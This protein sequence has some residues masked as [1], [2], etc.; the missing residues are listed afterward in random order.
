MVKNSKEII[1]T[2]L[3][4]WRNISIEEAKALRFGDLDRFEK[5]NSE[6]THIQSQLD[7]IL[8]DIDTSGFSRKVSELMEKI[9]KLNSS[10]LKELHKGTKELS[11][12]IALLRKNKVSMKG[13]KQNKSIA[14]R[15]MNKHT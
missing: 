1:L 9:R 13:Y 8:A 12:R 14:P 11:E 2:L 6:S 4:A 3:N 5:L 15:F 7:Y 10:L